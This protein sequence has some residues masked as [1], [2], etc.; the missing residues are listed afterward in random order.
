MSSW[1]EEKEKRRTQ[2]LEKHARLSALFREDRFAFERERKKM[3]E[4]AIQLA[5]DKEIQKSL[6]S[7]QASWERRMKG[8]GSDHNRLVL[9]KCFFWEHFHEV[10][11]PNIQQLNRLLNGSPDTE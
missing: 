6:R 9:S 1:A 4:E 10:W 5:E 3:I 2:S 8:A 11:Q 7:I